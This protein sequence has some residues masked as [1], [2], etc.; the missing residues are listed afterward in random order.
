MNRIVKVLNSAS[1]FNKMGPVFKY[2]LAMSVARDKEGGFTLIEVLMALGILTIALGALV[3]GLV[4][5]TRNAAYLQDRTIAHWVAANAA[6]ELRLRGNWP[7]VGMEQGSATMAGQEWYW[8]A[9]ITETEDQDLRRIDME[10]RGDDTEDRILE[11]LVAYVGK[12]F[13]L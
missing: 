1:A 12:P 8:T 11:T 10:V 4:E 7:S 13:D 6:A 2:P 3:K 9:R 5:N